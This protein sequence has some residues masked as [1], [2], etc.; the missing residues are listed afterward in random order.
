MGQTYHFL[1]GKA[2]RVT[3]R[4]EDSTAVAERG[5]DGSFRTRLRD[6]GGNELSQLAVANDGAGS[7][8]LE[9]S[10]AGERVFTQPRSD[11]H[12]TLDWANQQAYA[13]WK[14][15]PAAADDVEWKGRFVRSRGAKADAIEDRPLETETEFDNG[16]KVISTKNSREIQLS[17]RV[18]RRPTFVSHV[19][20]NGAD[21]GTMRWYGNEKVLA[22]DFPGL[23][24]GFVDEEHLKE[25]GG[26]TFTP[27][28][29]WANVQGLAFYEFHSRMKT[30]GKVAQA[31]PSLPQRLLNLVAPTVAANEVGCD[32]LHWLDDTVF[33]PCCD[34]HD[35]CYERNS[36]CSWKSW[37]W[38]SM[39]GNQWSCTVCNT[40]ASVCFVSGGAV[41]LDY[42]DVH[43][44]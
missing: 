34:S 15:R 11:V 39:W 23:T 18:R 8:R 1:E 33:R 29:A 10:A 12:P 19:L 36:G 32:Y 42:Q 21:V 25:S 4:F 16:L 13:L 3:T 7:S 31:R 41:L 27:T 43:L 30:Q 24:K 14:D 5:G 20:S 35:R 6:A 40:L 26:W 28:I 22:W 17:P 9:L 37:F 2:K 44:W 38:V